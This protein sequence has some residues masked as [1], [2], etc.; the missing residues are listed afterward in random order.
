MSDSP[1]PLAGVKVLDLSRILAAPF[2]TQM[3]GDLGADVIKVERP[4]S[5]DDARRYG[6]AFLKD[7]NGGGPPQGAMFLSAN[8]NKRSITI[9][10]SKPRGQELVRGLATRSDLLFENYKADTLAR[11]GLDYPSLALVNPRLIYCSI[12]GFGQTGPYRS[13]P[14]YDGIFQAAGGLM[15]VT[16]LPDGQPGAGPMKVG[17]SIVDVMTGY[18]AVI[19]ALAALHHR[20]QASGKGQ[21]IDLALFDVAVAA[22]SHY[23]MEYLVSGAPPIRKGAEGNGGMPSGVFSCADGVIYLAVG[24]DEQYMRLC[25]ALGRSDLASDPRY[26]SVV[27]RSDN[28]RPLVDA[29]NTTFS[30]WMKGEIIAKLEAV[31]VPACYVNDYAEVFADPQAQHRGLSVPVPHPYAPGLRHIA[32][33]IRYSETPLDDYRSPPLLGE[34][35]DRVLAAELGLNKTSLDDLRKTGVI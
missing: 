7:P 13:R 20:D 6:P 29:L 18:N 11:Y 1:K 19:A 14:G 30:E 5:G 21:H 32:N 24:N 3:L 16:G 31:S 23:P 33:P 9:D 27:A 28:R 26:G 35:T 34:H 22:A 25:G 15:S 17:P 10:I 8:R 2:A 4:G 12:T